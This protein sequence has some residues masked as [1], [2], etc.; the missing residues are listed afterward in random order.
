MFMESR[1]EEPPAQLRGAERRSEASTT[2]L[3]LLLTAM[4]CF[5]RL[6]P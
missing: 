4:F 1:T 6:I 2:L 3:P 5:S